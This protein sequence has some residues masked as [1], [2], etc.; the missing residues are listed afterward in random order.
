MSVGSLINSFIKNNPNEK[1]P[2]LSM[3]IEKLAD[4][5]QKYEV[6]RTVEEEDMVK[7]L[8]R[9]NASSQALY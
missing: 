4:S 3:L 1:V 8:N 2:E 9:L 5:L 7:T 6:C